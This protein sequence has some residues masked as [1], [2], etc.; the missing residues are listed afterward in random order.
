MHAFVTARPP[1]VTENSDTLFV[2]PKTSI[3]IDQ[4]RTIQ[5]FLSRKPIN[6]PCNTVVIFE[7]HLLTVPAQNALLKSLEEPPANAQI[8]LVTSQPD[9]LLF[10]VVSRC[11]VSNENTSVPTDLDLPQKYLQLTTPQERLQF[12]DTQAFTKQEAL[13]FLHNLEH[14]LHQQISRGEYPKNTKIYEYLHT[15]RKYLNANCN[16]K[17]VLDNI[18]FS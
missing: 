7:A 8:Y 14:S 2:T 3:T 17:L 1:S 5:H 10:T 6:S 9:Q 13:E 12:F 4:V 11:Q 16:T 18:T 15:A